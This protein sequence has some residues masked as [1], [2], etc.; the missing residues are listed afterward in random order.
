MLKSVDLPALSCVLRSEV[1]ISNAAVMSVPALPVLFFCLWHV[2]DEI[3]GTL[4][5]GTFG[6]VM[7][8]ID[9]RRYVRVNDAAKHSTA[10][11]R[12]RRLPVFFFIIGNWCGFNL[13]CDKQ[14]KSYFD[15]FP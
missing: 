12:D 13:N 14:V 8:C 1:S 6:R 5:E 15:H 3:V 4:G 10:L 7:E 11:S 2:A 9:H